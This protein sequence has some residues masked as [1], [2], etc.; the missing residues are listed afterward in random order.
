MSRQCLQEHTIEAPRTITGPIKNR[1]LIRITSN[2]WI[3]FSPSVKSV[4]DDLRLWNKHFLLLFRR[5]EQ[6]SSLQYL[7]IIT[8][9]YLLQSPL[10]VYLNSMDSNGHLFH[11][12]NHTLSRWHGIDGGLSAAAHSCRLRNNQCGAWLAP[13]TP[14]SQTAFQRGPS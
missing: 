12:S 13:D 14:E 9:R 5:L 3:R 6:S 11:D 8:N 4:S 2:T 1:N 10:V 7:W